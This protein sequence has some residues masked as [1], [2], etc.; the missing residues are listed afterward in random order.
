[1]SNRLDL[2]SGETEAYFHITGL[3]NGLGSNKF[4]DHNDRNFCWCLVTLSIK[5]RYFLF[6][7][8]EDEMLNFGEVIYL[9]DCLNDLLND[10]FDSACSVSFIEPDL[11]FELHPK[12]DLR[13]L[14]NIWVREG[15]EIQDISVDLIISLSDMKTGYNGQT[16]SF[17]LDRGEIESLWGYLNEVIPLLDNQWVESISS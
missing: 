8:T 14:K 11:K 10:Q 15:M 1:M 12:L 4:E 13:T 2:S 6:N 7:R 17:P 16:Y 9:R 5:N 3:G